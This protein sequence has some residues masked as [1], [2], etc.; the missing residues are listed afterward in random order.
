[1]KVARQKNHL[2]GQILYRTPG[3]KNGFIIDFDGKKIKNHYFF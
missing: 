2:R 3:P 1:M